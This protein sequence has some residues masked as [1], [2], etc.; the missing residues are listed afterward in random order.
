LYDIIYPSWEINGKKNIKL[1]KKE[2]KFNDNNKIKIKEYINWIKYEKIYKETALTAKE[3]KLNK[4]NWEIFKF[5]Y[6]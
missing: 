6:F 3:L 2:W 1:N 4:S 5:N